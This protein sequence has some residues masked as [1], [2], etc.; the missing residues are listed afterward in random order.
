VQGAGLSNMGNT[1]FLNATLQCITHTVPLFLKLCSNDHFTP[2]SCMD[3]F[4]QLTNVLF[5]NTFCFIL[6]CM[7]RTTVNLQIM[8][9]GSV[10][11]VPLKNMLTNQFE[12]P[13]LL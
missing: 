4:V 10:L 11:S 8:R 2:C 1:C 13:D 6:V 12:G 5:F 7:I 3:N 9:M